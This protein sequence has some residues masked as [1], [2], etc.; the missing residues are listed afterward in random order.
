MIFILVGEMPFFIICRLRKLALRLVCG[1]KFVLN[2]ASF[3]I[4]ESV[5]TAAS[6]SI[7]KRTHDSKS[8]RIRY[9]VDHSCGP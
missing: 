3:S 5:T 4:F 9:S 7:R 2:M 1:W 6:T 8:T